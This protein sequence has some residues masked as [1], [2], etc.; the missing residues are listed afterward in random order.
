MPRRVIHRT[1]ARR[2]TQN[3][4]HD[5]ARILAILDEG[6]VCHL[7]FVDADHPVCVPT[8][9]ARLGDHVYVHGSA[10]SRAL[11]ASTGGLPV[12][13]TVTLVDGLVLARSAFHHSIN[14]RSVIVFGIA[15]LVEDRKARLAAV[16]AFTERIAPG[17]S[18]DVR[19]PSAQEMKATAI[20]RLALTEVSA[21]VRQGPPVDRAE[22]YALDH[23]A[24][25]IPLKLE[26]LVPQPDPKLRPG[27]HAPDNLHR[28]LVP[29]GRDTAPEVPEWEV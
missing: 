28:T 18:A 6:F 21:K 14:Y 24:G 7:A 13:L 12:C 9:Y 17:R 26:R 3:A 27:I 25:V 1:R 5:P 15:E 22:D 19:P 2:V 11:Q 16:Q 20:V 23:W 29:E 10:A 4:V 8:L